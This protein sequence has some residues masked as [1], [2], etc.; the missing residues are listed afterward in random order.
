MVIVNVDLCELHSQYHWSRGI[1]WSDLEYDRSLY[2]Q[3]G[4]NDHLF[5]DKCMQPFNLSLIPLHMLPCLHSCKKNMQNSISPVGKNTLIL[6]LSI[7]KNRFTPRCKGYNSVC[8]LCCHRH[9]FSIPPF[10][11]L[12]VM[13]VWWQLVLE[14]CFCITWKEILFSHVCLVPDVQLTLCH[15][16]STYIPKSP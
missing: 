9:I 12:P 15:K 1:Y 4:S 10:S 7:F 11:Y 3:R 16:S 5:S 6:S 13:E 2:M 8:E 14:C